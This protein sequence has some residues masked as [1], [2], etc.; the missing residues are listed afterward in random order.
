MTNASGISDEEFLRLDP[1]TANNTA[2]GRSGE[3]CERLRRLYR[4]HRGIDI[5]TW[6]REPKPPSDPV[7]GFGTWLIVLGVVGAFASFFFPVSVETSGLYG[8]PDRVANIDRIALRHMCLAASAT[9]FVGGCVMFAAGYVARAVR[10][11]VPT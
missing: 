10:S 6:R 1:D 3:E 7:Q 8:V 5:E 9:S 2:L 11:S 4:E